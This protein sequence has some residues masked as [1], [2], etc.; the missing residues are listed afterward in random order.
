MSA[1]AVVFGGTN[2]SFTGYPSPLC[3]APY[4]KP[5]KPITFNSQWE[6]DQYNEEVRRYNSELESY[7][8][9]VREYLENAKNDISRIREK[10]NQ[11]IDEAN[12]L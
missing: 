12:S 9:C 5:Y 8:S 4:T 2:M 3:T 11:V 7:Y 10:M 6:V 1:E